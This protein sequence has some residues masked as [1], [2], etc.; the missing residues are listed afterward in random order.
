VIPV[1]DPHAQYA[2][3]K[4]DIDAAIARV[5]A[6]GRY[7]LGD[8]V[9]ALEKELAAAHGVAHGV[10]VG[11]GTDALVVALRALGVQPGDEVVTVAHTAVATVAAVRLAGATPVL[12]DVDAHDGIDPDGLARALSTRTRAVIAV[13]LYGMPVD[14]DA[15]VAVCARA[16]VPLVEDCAQAHGAR[17]RGRPVGSFGAAGCFSFYPTKNLGALGDG[18]MLV[19]GDAA[20][21]TRAR[22]LREYGW[23]ERYVSATEGTNSRL[24]ELQAAVLRVKLAGLDAD[25]AR[26]R[27]IAAV[28]EDGLAGLPLE[29]PRTRP[30][31]EPVHHLYVVRTD[32]REAL[33]AALAARGVGTAVHYPVPVHLQ[34]AYRGRVVTLDMPRTEGLARRV[35]SLPMF[36][37]LDRARVDAVVAAMRAAHAG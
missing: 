5:L 26:R 19:T 20:L 12:V 28:Y 8:E 14:L 1:A 24:D 2:A 9:A 23:E 15:V 10:G 35:L 32:R 11:T 4:G 33:Q 18:G 21:A 7:V 31:A 22:R 3:R 30:G 37:E 13:H 29:L 6:A 34:P 36:P 25:N 16:G 27:A 17:W